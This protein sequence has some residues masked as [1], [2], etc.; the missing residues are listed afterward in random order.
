MKMDIKRS[1]SSIAVLH[2][3]CFSCWAEELTSPHGTLEFH[4]AG[5]HKWEHK[6]PKKMGWDYIYGA[7]TQ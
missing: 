1:G 3:M 5:D 4:R 2:K 6:V 7:F